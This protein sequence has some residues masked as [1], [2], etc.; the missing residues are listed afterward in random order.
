MGIKNP[1]KAKKEEKSHVVIPVER[2]I[3][4]KE[5]MNLVASFICSHEG[6]PI[7]NASAGQKGNNHIVQVRKKVTNA[8]EVYTVQFSFLPKACIVDFSTSI[9]KPEINEKD[10]GKGIGMIGGI[11]AAG[12]M[13]VPVATLGIG[14]ATVTA[15]V[16]SAKGKKNKTRKLKDNVFELISDYLGG[17][18]YTQI[19]EIDVE[20]TNIEGNKTAETLAQICECGY[21]F[22]QKMQ[23]C[24]QCGKKVVEPAER[25]CECGNII[26]QGTKF[27]PQCGKSVL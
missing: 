4:E 2:E 16:V 25:I 20:N 22:K 26:S 7:G 1:D 14:A 21:V 5:L 6:I 12:M 3:D 24:P 19:K 17:V 10:F 18:P 27:C 11:V 15:G 8:F 13:I 9:E 23:F